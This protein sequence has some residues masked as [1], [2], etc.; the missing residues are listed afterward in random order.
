[1]NGASILRCAKAELSCMRIIQFAD[2][3]CELVVS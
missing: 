2:G 3:L 1:M